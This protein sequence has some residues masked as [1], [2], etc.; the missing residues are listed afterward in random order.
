M[1][2]LLPFICICALL[3]STLITNS[4]CQPCTPMM[5]TGG[6]EK[7]AFRVLP[8]ELHEV[9][10][11][12]GPFL[13]ALKLNARALLDY[14]PDRFL[15]K[16]RSEAGLP[17]KAEHYAGWEADTLAGHSLGHY[18]SACSMMYRA[19]GDQRFLARVDYIVDELETCQKTDGRGYIGAF[20]GGKRVME[21]EIAKGNIRAKSFN[22]N[23]I[24]APFYT[25]HKVL[26]GLHDAYR[27]CGNRKA[28]EIRKH[29]ADWLAGV[30]LGLP[31]DQVQDMLQCEHGGI[32]EA[33]AD[34]Y[35]D[36][37]DEKYLK[38][39]RLFYHKA[40]LEPLAKGEDILPGK[41]AN[42][43]IP[44]IIGL[45]R[46]YELT[47]EKK[48]R[49]TA[50]FFWERVTG[51]HSYITGGHGNHE[52]FG[53]PDKLRDRLSEGT[54]ETCNVYNMLKLSQ[55]LFTWE[56]AARV[57]D[58]YER[59]LFNHIL[60]SQHPG[61]GRVVY[62]LSLDMGGYKVYQDPQ[63]FTCCIGTG[64]ENHAKYGGNIF[65]HN[66]QELF[67][68]QYIAAE[69]SWRQKGVRVRQSTGYPQQQGTA[70]DFTCRRPVCLTLQ[71]R[72]PF[73]AQKGIEISINGRNLKTSAYKPG[74][75]IPLRRKWQ[76]GDR[77]EVKIPFSLR[78]EAMPDDPGRI[79]V[80]Y[81]PLA[82][83][84]DLGPRNDPAAGDFSY[85]P[86]LLTADRNP[87][88]WIAPVGSEINTFTTI[89]VG[90]P[91]EILLKPFYQVH[92]RRYSLYWD[93]LT[94][95]A[96]AEK[97]EA[98]KR[99]LEYKKKLAE[100]TVDFVQPGDMAAERAH[101]FQGE[102]TG[103]DSFKERQFR[104]AREGWFS[105]DMKVFKGQ[106]MALV[107][108]YWGGFPGAKAFDIL[109]DGEKIAAEN[110]SGKQ[111]GRFID[112]EYAIP[113]RLSFAKQQVA[114]KFA[115]QPGNTAGPV[116]AVRI[117][118]R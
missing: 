5:R 53:P 36:T 63:W 101:H 2:Y 35:A 23:G 38:M 99:Q 64:M 113:D 43:Q 104:E 90:R 33:L 106:P 100:M 41:H 58:F 115:A 12:D 75:F 39:S 71:I 98:N 51:H 25:Q 89:G 86:V 107:V 66:E 84:G 9:K 91:R 92:E 97:Q 83:A 96:W 10:L 28:L 118:K 30:V 20:P 14:E 46:L 69:V 11:L 42:T 70:F 81:G 31:G 32:N 73:W 29:F 18:L 59:A 60:A 88:N 111:E 16:F 105:Y 102:K 110:I 50:A 17:P 6:A 1:K 15:A 103:I 37:G 109:I 68:F 34:L 78:L 4:C 52:Y 49:D 93:M 13:H 80:L 72:Y 47:G 116:F 76:T 82:L 114:V 48:D 55:R 19:A 7:I 117:I 94:G 77:V 22:L 45:A 87:A 21:Q 40:I 95:A 65:F 24:W 112:I 61:D 62:N 85:I 57:A 74:S 26:S 27:L 8:F 56:A 79:A 108:E 3:G 44:K 67:V 54:S